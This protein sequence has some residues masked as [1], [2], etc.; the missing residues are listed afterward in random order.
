[1][2]AD[3]SEYRRREYNKKMRQKTVGF[4]VLAAMTISVLSAC[5][6]VSQDMEVNSNNQKVFTLKTYVQVVTT[7]DY[8]VATNQNP[9]LLNQFIFTPQ[10]KD[11]YVAVLK[12]TGPA[13]SQLSWGRATLLPDNSTTAGIFTALTPTS[14]QKPRFK[15]MSYDKTDFE[16]QATDFTKTRVSFEPAKFRWESDS[17]SLPADLE[18]YWVAFYDSQGNYALRVIE[19]KSVSGNETVSV[20]EI[21]AYETFVSALLITQQVSTVNRFDKP[22]T[23]TQVLELFSPLFFEAINYAYPPNQV[24]RFNVKEPQ[25]KFNRKVENDLLAIMALYVTDKK[26]AL[27][28]IDSRR[29]ALPLPDNAIVILRN[30][31]ARALAAPPLV[32]SPTG[33]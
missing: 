27:N 4:A 16:L 23:R 18:N 12:K 21:N 29:Q 3:L 17:K 19:Q 8:R 24:D 2:A 10:T 9:A 14:N 32:Q 13:F 1:M 30:T 31:I 20:G 5:G 28:Y 11:V 25:F 33:P 26:E 7:A 22:V 15:S 6:K